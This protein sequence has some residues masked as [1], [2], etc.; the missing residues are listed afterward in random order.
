MLPSLVRR[1]CGQPEEGDALLIIFHS[2]PNTSC[3]DPWNG[4]WKK[5]RSHVSFPVANIVG[6]VDCITYRVRF[7]ANEW[8]SKFKIIRVIICRGLSMCSLGYHP[9]FP[10][11]L[12]PNPVGFG[13][14]VIQRFPEPGVRQGL[15]CSQ[16]FVR[17]VY[18]YPFQQV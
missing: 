9:S 17:V 8:W 11:L 3:I 16:A 15:L 7:D 18:E 10:F 2:L 12:S 4:K 5:P 13:A 14:V 1:L 6:H